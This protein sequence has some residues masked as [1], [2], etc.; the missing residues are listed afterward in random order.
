MKWAGYLLG[1]F[2]FFAPIFFAYAAIVPQCPP[3][4]CRACDLVT[5]ANNVI[6]FLIY[7][8]IF[9][10]VG[11]VVVIGFSAVVSGES[12]AHE[13]A[14]T[15]TNIVV[16]IIIMLSGWLIIDTIMK[17]L[18]GG[19]LGPW[20][21]VE[22]INNPA[23]Q[24][25]SGQT[26]GG[27]TIDPVTGLVSSVVGVGDCSPSA[28]SQTFGGQA[29]VMSCIAQ[30]E[31]SCIAG[32]QSTVDRTSVGGDAFSIGLYQV[33]LTVH[34]LNEPGC[35]ALNGGQPLNCISAF[36]G[37]NRGA[38]V[39]DRG[40]YDRCVSAAAN[41]SCNTAVAQSL[42]RTQQGLGHWSTYNDGGCR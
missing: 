35:T 11:S 34:N 38:V 3:T 17:V 9:V 12:A 8:S 6:K 37:R 14:G 24:Q 40:L 30:R 2:L 21:A 29:A 39:V 31:S 5:L 19:R 42:L 32:R 41:V 13:L 33:N 7:M 1:L 10:A 25:P 20:N 18:V 22:C 36:Q 15:F 16:G 23:M 26:M 27:T 28:L 4:G